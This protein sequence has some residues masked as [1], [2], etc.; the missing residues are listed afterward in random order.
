[1]EEGRP[2]RAEKY[3][4]GGRACMKETTEQLFARAQDAIEAA[5]ILWTKEK[6]DIAD[7]RAY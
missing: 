5:D 2:A 7:G 6:T 3:P 4:R 1:M